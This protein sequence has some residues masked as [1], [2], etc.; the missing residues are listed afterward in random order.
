MTMR[1][2]AQRRKPWKQRTWL[3]PMKRNFS[4]HGFTLIELLVVISIIALLISILLPALSAARDAGRAVQCLSNL[5]QHALVNTLYADANDDHSLPLRTPR[6]NESGEQW[7]AKWHELPF[8]FEALNTRREWRDSEAVI[9]IDR[10]CPMSYGVQHGNTDGLT[11]PM[12]SYGING[13]DYDWSGT[14]PNRHVHIRR[15]QVVNPS[16][17]M[18]MADALDT[19]MSKPNS[20]AYLSEVQTIEA[21]ET[22]QIAYRHAG[23]TQAVMFDGHAE[24]IPRADAEVTPPHVNTDHALWDLNQ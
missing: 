14:N 16:T 12:W 4:Q 8:Y 13:T 23:S 2:F 7:E 5:R 15:Y 18:W 10:L 21:G 19:Q 9:A 1:M 20:M 11:R 17:S 3:I 22:N 24:S 6:I